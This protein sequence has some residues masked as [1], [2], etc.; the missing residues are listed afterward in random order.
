MPIRALQHWVVPGRDSL[1]LGLP[2]P[3]SMMV[4]A[5]GMVVSAVARLE[6]VVEDMFVRVPRPQ[7]PPYGLV[8]RP[9]LW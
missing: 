8:S 2:Q 4:S 3:V 9:A 6:H 1:L 5:T 7:R